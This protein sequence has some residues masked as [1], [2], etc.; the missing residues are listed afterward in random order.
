M[1]V[2]GRSLRLRVE[3]LE[4]VQTLREAGRP[5]L[6]TSW[7]GR[8]L[9]LT[10]H[11]RGLLQMLM[12]SQSRDGDRIAAICEMLGYATVRGS[13]SRS[14]TRALREFARWLKRGGVGGHVLDG[15]R[16]PA[17]EIKPGL[18]ALAR[19]SQ[20]AIVPVYA[21][22]QHRWEARSWDRMQIARPFS[23]VLVRYG[24]PV[25][26]AA[27]LDEEASEKLRVELERQ[28]KS[29]YVRLERDLRSAQAVADPPSG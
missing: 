7:H 2:H 25:E 20:A 5:V 14:G 29:E 24:P 18:I 26:V 4:G 19:L 17:G 1:R 11:V 12:I 13:S 28:M 10:F 15:P 9:L 8:I 16:G 6:L 27:D 23:R 22:A 3:G 21:S